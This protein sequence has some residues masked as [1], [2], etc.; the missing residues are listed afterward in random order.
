MAHP[1]GLRPKC[2]HSALFVVYLESPNFTP[3]ALTGRIWTS[4]DAFS[5]CVNMP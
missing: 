1:A 3:R 4:S 5:I 2:G